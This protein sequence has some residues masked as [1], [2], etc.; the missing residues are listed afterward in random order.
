MFS[1]QDVTLILTGEIFSFTKSFK[2]SSKIGQ[3]QRPVA[4]HFVVADSL[5]TGDGPESETLN[6]SP[7]AHIL[8]N[9]P[10]K[11]NIS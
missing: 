3:S 5:L 8:G 9:Q 4:A 6:R 7:S 11:N 10:R 2:T 1:S